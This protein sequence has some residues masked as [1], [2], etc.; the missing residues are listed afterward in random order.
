MSPFHAYKGAPAAI[1]ALAGSLWLTGCNL[2]SSDPPD[3]DIHKS[4][5]VNPE[6]D[7]FNTASQRTFSVTEGI[8]RAGKDTVFA[9]R[10]LQITRVGDTVVGGVSRKHV[11]V[12]TSPAPSGALA[13]LGLNPDRLFFDSTVIL[14]PGPALRFPDTPR[15]GWALDTTVG[16][17]RFVRAFGG[18]A[19]V[20]AAGLYHDC[21][22]FSESV[23]WNGALVS[24][25]NYYFGGWGLVLHRQEWKA[26]APAAITGG[27][28]WREIRAAN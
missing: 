18:S 9:V 2:F 15:A 3:V 8:L 22:V 17:L 25:G 14:D 20:K 23:Y 13:L 16:D 1:F 4:A 27:T 24:T 19:T 10:D 12:Q 11:A 7:L 28:F 26:Y 6:S 21:W 5:A